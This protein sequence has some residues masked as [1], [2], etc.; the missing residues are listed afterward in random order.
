MASGLSLKVV[1]SCSKVG[2]SRSICPSSLEVRSEEG[3]EA[4]LLVDVFIVI[5]IEECSTVQLEEDR[6]LEKLAILK[7]RRARVSALYLPNFLYST[8]TGQ[9]DR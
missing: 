2:S 5:V 6:R 7:N 4:W 9:K 1:E 8:N 3:E